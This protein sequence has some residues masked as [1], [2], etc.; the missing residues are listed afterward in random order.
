MELLCT[1]EKH[2]APTPG[3]FSEGLDL[4]TRERLKSTSKL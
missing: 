3:P 4:F 2:V 1:N